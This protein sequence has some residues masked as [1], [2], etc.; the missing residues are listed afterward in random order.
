MEQIWLIGDRFVNSTA[1]SYWTSRQQFIPSNF[2]VR[3]A[4][5]GQRSGKNA[6]GRII[7]SLTHLFNSESTFPKW[8]IVVPEG[9]IIKDIVYSKYGVSATYGLLI[10]YT[11]TAMDKIIK[12]FMEKGDVR[13]KG[14]KFD[15]PHILW[16]APII[17]T[18]LSNNPLRIKFIRGLYTAASMHERVIVLPLRSGW[19][20]EAPSQVVNNYITHTGLITYWEAVDNTIKF[21]DIK[22]M[23]NYGLKLN[24]VF[25]KEK[26][27]NEAEIVLTRYEQKVS[28]R[29]DFRAQIQSMQVRQFFEHRSTSVEEAERRAMQQR[30]SRAQQNTQPDSTTGRADDPKQPTTEQHQHGGPWRVSE[31]PSTSQTSPRKLQEITFQRLSIK[32]AR[33]PTHRS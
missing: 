19:N 14:N 11:M 30:E 13:P 25:Q 12:D 15:Y 23:R 20:P 22:V 21:A 5:L 3:V 7:N 27:K 33:F 28:Q 16:M 8:I 2:D 26:I 32:T 31:L 17:H 1:R 4:A 18:N 9:D 6:I 29:D 24:Q 10:E